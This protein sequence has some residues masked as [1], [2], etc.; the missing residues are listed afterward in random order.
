MRSEADLDIGKVK[1]KSDLKIR[2]TSELDLDIVEVKNRLT[3]K[4]NVNFRSQSLQNKTIG[5]CTS[6]VT[7][8]EL[9]LKWLRLYIY[10]S[11]HKCRSS[12]LCQSIP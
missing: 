4:N 8:A 11:S 12:F 1:N 6:K 2:M 7:S 10:K 9:M 3:S 5:K